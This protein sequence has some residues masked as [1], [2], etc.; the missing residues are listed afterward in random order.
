MKLAQRVHDCERAVGL[1]QAMPAGPDRVARNNTAD[2]ELI[3]AEQALSHCLSGQGSAPIK[4]E[5]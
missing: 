3:K 5:R 4:V 1:A 2:L